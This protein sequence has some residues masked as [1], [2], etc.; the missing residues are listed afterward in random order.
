MIPPILAAAALVID[1]CFSGTPSTQTQQCILQ[2]L[3]KLIASDGAQGDQFG[4]SVSIGCGRLAVG[5]WQLYAEGPGAVYVFRL[6]DNGSPSDPSDDIWLQQAKLSA[7]DGVA[8]DKFGGS[9]S[10]SCN[11]IVAGARA[12]NVGTG[13][14]YVFRLN[15]NATP[16]DPTDDSWV[17]AVK[18]GPFGGFSAAWF[19]SSVA[20]SENRIVVGAK[21][22]SPVGPLSGAAY[23]FRLDDNETPSN[24]DDDFWMQEDVLVADDGDGYDYVGHSV[25]IARD[26]IVVGAPLSDDA[27]SDDQFCDS[28]SAYVFR[29]SDNGTPSDPRDDSW[30]QEVKLTASK[31][32]PDNEFGVSVSTTGDLVIVGAINDGTVCSAESEDCYSGSAHV[33]RR[34]GSGTPTD[35]SDDSWVREAQL[36]A[37]DASPGDRFGFSLSTTGERVVVGANH[38]PR[39]HVFRRD[40][41]DTPS[42][43]TDDSWLQEASLVAPG[44][45]LRAPVSMEGNVVVV[46]A[47]YGRP[48]GSNSGSAFVFA[49]SDPFCGDEC[50]NG[51]E[52]CRTCP[53]D[54]LPGCGDGCCMAG[55]NA[56]MCPQDCSEPSCGDGC[57][58]GDEDCSTCPQDCLSCGD[59]CCADT[60]NACTCTQD[61][62]EPVCGD[63]C[64]NGDDDLSNCPGDC[65]V[66]LSTEVADLVGYY[67]GLAGETHDSDFDFSQEFLAVHDAWLHLQGIGD[68]MPSGFWFLASLD[69]VRSPNQFLLAK[70]AFDVVVPLTPTESAL[71]GAGTVHLRIFVTG[72]CDIGA[73]VTDAALWFAAVPIQGRTSLADFA[74]LQKCFTGS[75]GGVLPTCTGFN[76]DGDDDIDLHDYGAF[77][78]G[79]TGP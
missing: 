61:C 68:L 11:W 35:R 30:T 17:Q 44:I 20:T 77:R 46:G 56:C 12:A 19:G 63:G 10:V 41:S 3:Q 47:P 43:Q 31:P 52:D 65:S 71:D 48:W 25:S 1:A 79:L 67:A 69:G 13:A 54:C 50:C 28:G 73:Q 9:V 76:Y 78:R 24:P 26:T 57:C 40:D 7:S 37:A 75:G 27:C 21:R 59:G 38:S 72:C 66:E 29:R 14:V 23:V 70:T 51:D 64:C 6:D 5:A 74:D 53:Q 16:S 49:L 42:D 18:L 22:A 45:T 55:E 36:M 2:P 58:N 15:D 32:V 33:F 34:D 39:A 60:E 62:S 4:Y 8:N